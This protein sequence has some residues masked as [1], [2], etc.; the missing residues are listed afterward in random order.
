MNEGY[1]VWEEGCADDAQEFIGISSEEDA[2]IAGAEIF[3]EG[4]A[5]PIKVVVKCPTGKK[6]KWEVKLSAVR[7]TE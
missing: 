6:S 3:S 4:V 5:M 2:A 1:L 7:L